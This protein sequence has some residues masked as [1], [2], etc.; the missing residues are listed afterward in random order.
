MCASDSPFAYVSAVSIMLMPFSNAIWMMSCRGGEHAKSL[1]E[2]RTCLD[3]I[4][5]HAATESEPCA[6]SVIVMRLPL[7]ARMYTKRWLLTSTQRQQ[8]HT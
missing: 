7:S 1:H 2:E 8:R 4:A 5:F 3:R 6:T